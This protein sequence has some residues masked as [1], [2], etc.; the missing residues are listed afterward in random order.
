M[1]PSVR[2][3]PR[4]IDPRRRIRQTAEADRNS[5]PKSSPSSCGVRRIIGA[6][7]AAATTSV[8]RTYRAAAALL[9][10]PDWRA[11]SEGKATS[12]TDVPTRTENELSVVATT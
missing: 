1:A 8:V 9:S 11:A 5:G 2:L 4:A 3:R 12:A 7:A 10:G 6:V